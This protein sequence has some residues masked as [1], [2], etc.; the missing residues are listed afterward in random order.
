MLGINT[1]G[2]AAPMLSPRAAAAQPARSRQKVPAILW[3]N[4][5]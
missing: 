5:R 2:N 4:C 1:S 3:A